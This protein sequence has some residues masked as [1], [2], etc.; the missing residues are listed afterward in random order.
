MEKGENF[1]Q[2]IDGFS[3]NL[4]SSGGI[5]TT[6]PSRQAATGLPKTLCFQTAC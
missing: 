3:G 4:I 2:S 6:L 5:Q 1:S